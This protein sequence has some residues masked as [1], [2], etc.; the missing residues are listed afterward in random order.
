MREPKK[1]NPTL[2]PFD[3]STRI[4]IEQRNTQT[5]TMQ[6]SP[7]TIAV[8]KSADGGS[9]FGAPVRVAAEWSPYVGY[10]RGPLI[11]L[12]SRGLSMVRWMGAVLQGIHGKPH[13][14]KGQ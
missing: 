2:T 1:N 5:G 8:V 9:P 12:D 6:T 4:S 14:L 7:N 11:L 13:A 3:C 10:Q